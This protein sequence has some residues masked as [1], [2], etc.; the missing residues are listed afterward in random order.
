MEVSVE[1]LRRFPAIHVPCIPFLVGTR[2][3]PSWAVL[4]RESTPPF[5]RDTE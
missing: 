1:M 3:L 5:V 4:Y 2:P